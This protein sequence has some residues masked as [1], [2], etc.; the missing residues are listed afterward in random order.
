MKILFRKTVIVFIYLLGLIQGVYSQDKQLFK[1][2]PVNDSLTLPYFGRFATEQN[3]YY[4]FDF[5]DSSKISEIEDL[6]RIAYYQEGLIEIYKQIP[7]SLVFNA[8]SELLGFEGNQSVYIHQG[9]R[10]KGPLLC[11]SCI[12]HDDITV[13]LYALFLVNVL[14]LRERAASYAPIYAI[15][16]KRT[17]RRNDERDI[18]LAYGKYR[19]WFLK[20]QKTGLKQARKKNIY[21]L[22]L[23]DRTLSWKRLK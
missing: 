8:I 6:F 4:A 23:R 20:I 22:S 13:Q 14:Y 5:A 17:G 18:A 12:H 15:Y 19:K 10:L 9:I 1:L 16:D 3:I 21:P 11:I 7:D 2:Y